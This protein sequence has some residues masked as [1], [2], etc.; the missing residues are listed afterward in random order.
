MELCCNTIIYL[1]FH[2]FVLLGSLFYLKSFNTL[3]KPDNLNIMGL[4]D[5]LWLTI[6]TLVAL[7]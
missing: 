6:E 1:L 2:Y 7:N 4:N 3:E 5:L